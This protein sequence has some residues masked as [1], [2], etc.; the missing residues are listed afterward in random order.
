M[1]L[2]LAASL[3]SFAL[4]VPTLASQVPYSQAQ[5]AIDLKALPPEF[6]AVLSE[7]RKLAELSP[8]ELKARIKLL[9]QAAALPDLPPALHDQIVAMADATKKEFDARAQAAA[10]PAAPAVEPKAQVV[11]VAPAAP[12]VQ[13][14]AQVVQIGRAHV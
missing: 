13:P 12:V 3:L 1:K 8:D 5:T 11:P 6:A 7:K 14:K 9:Q 10:A 2:K 4:F